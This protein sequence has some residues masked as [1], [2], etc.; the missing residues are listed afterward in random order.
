M[1][2]RK[3][4][5]LV[6]FLSLTNIGLAAQKRA[7]LIGISHYTPGQGIDDLSTTGP[8]LTSRPWRVS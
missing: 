1:I 8:G 3:L 2:A 4:G 5:G 6:L 7:L